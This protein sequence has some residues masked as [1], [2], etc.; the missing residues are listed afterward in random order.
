MDQRC[1]CQNNGYYVSSLSRMILLAHAQITNG[2]RHQHVKLCTPDIVP[3]KFDG[4]YMVLCGDKRIRCVY[5]A[6]Y[7]WQFNERSFTHICSFKRVWLAAQLQSHCRLPIMNKNMLQNIACK[8]T[9]RYT[10]LRI[11]NILL[12]GIGE[13]LVLSV[14][15]ASYW[16]V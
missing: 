5:F 10:C 12:I 7:S 6:R 11:D 9:E 13:N 8:T 2:R 1:L 14:L 15:F 3:G 4:K 16:N